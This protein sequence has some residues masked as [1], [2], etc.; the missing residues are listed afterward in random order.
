[1]N[2]PTKQKE[3]QMEQTNLWL[4]GGSKV[5]KGRDK[6]GDWDRQITHYT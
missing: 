4:W 2:L 1:M 6:L 5:G 3:L